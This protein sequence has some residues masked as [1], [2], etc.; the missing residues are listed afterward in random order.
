MSVQ[1]KAEESLTCS[2]VDV[3]TIIDGSDCCVVIDQVY[4]NE[5]DAQAALA[6]FTEKARKTESEPCQ[7]QSAINPVE[8]GVQLK[9][10]FTFSCQA[11]AMIFELANR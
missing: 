11:E 10:N 6:K 5:A 7:I 4:A 2:C 1:C 8:G 9:A 3:G